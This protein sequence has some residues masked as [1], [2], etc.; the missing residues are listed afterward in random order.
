[1]AKFAFEARDR[2]GRPRSGVLDR[3]TR[4]A[5]VESLR[6]RDWMVL[7]VAADQPATSVDLLES[8]RPGNW[9]GVRMV[10][11][12]LSL[13]QLSVM[14][15]SGLA[16]L[17]SIRMLYEHVERR[18]L[19]KVWETVADDILGGSTMTEALQRHKCFPPVAVQLARVGEQTGELNITLRRAAD[20]LEHRR[21]LRSQII[22]ALAYPLIVFMAAVG[23][24]AFMVFNV[25][26][27]LQNF[28]SSLG[29]S[30]P[31][32][33]QMM[34]DVTNFVN[35]YAL[36]G[37]AG[38]V[39]LIGGTIAMRMWPPGRL[40]SDRQLL[41]V[42]MIGSTFRIGSSAALSRNMQMLLASGVPLLEALKSVEKLLGNQF[43]SQQ[44]TEC[45]AA[46]VEGST[47]ADAI[48]ARGFTPMLTRIV[49]IG[50]SSGRLDEVLDEAAN[51]YEDQL[52]RAIRRMAA[53]IEPAMLVIVGG[54]VG[55]VYI[56]F[57]MALF[58]AAG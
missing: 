1:M 49:A 38:L 15:A 17:D 8:I 11:V 46:V 18:S 35:E 34:V 28:L 55:F 57:F 23:V 41:R 45:R 53:L 36:Y 22:S 42:P 26:P 29:R 21:R 10:D 19:R 54:I 39:V 52:A 3:P 14:L 51:Y 33:T 58:A 24:A 25:I 9:L 48:K 50:E 6:Q 30:L 16:L 13:R 20:I 37:L 40:W 5:V 7:E 27:K 4:E 2:Q 31:P 12:E 47:L 56:S 43:L 44:I 32:L